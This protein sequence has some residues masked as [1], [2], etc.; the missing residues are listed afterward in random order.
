MVD[1]HRN[2]FIGK[3]AG[4]LRGQGLLMA[5][6]SEGVLI[7][8]G[9]TVVAGDA[10]GGEA[11]GEQRGRVVLGEP[12]IG[13]GLEAAQGEQAH[14]FDAAG[15]DDAVAAGADAQIGHGNGLKAGGAEAIDGDAGNFDR[16]AGAQSGPAGDVPAL[17]ALRLGAAED[18]VVDFGACRGRNLV[19]SSAQGNCGQ[20]VGAGGG[21]RAFGG[22]ANR[23]ANGADENGFGMGMLRAIHATIL[24]TREVATA[25][26]WSQS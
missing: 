4:G 23:G 24:A 13:A 18:D 7:F 14:G 20:I 22:A 17:L 26:R 12:G 25:H 10:L 5:R 3:A 16:Q 21:E 15:H 6:E 2:E 11:H 1:L 19:Q 9:D 8:A